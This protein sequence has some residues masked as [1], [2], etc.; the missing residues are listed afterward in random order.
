M[1][2]G[3]AGPANLRSN[4]KAKQAQAQ[5]FA[6]NLRGLVEGFRQK[7]FTQTEMAGELNR[8][9]IATPK[10]CG[11]WS[12]TQVQRLL[13]RLGLRRKTANAA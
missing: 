4:V 3:K 5:A 7:G 2:L 12:L 10:G 6:E 8:L 11:E 9:K 1:V 13:D